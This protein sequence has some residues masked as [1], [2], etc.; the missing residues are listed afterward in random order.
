MLNQPT[1]D[2]QETPLFYAM[3]FIKDKLEKKLMVKTLIGLGADPTLKNHKGLYSYQAYADEYGMDDAALF[4]ERSIYFDQHKNKLKQIGSVFELDQDISK[5]NAQ[6]L[7]GLILDNWKEFIHDKPLEERLKDDLELAIA[8]KGKIGETLSEV[9][10]VQP[11]DAN[12]EYN[13][14]KSELKKKQIEIVGRDI[15]NSFQRFH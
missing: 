12:K 8:K 5:A 10:H 14:M 1:E 13:A 15:I 7:K 6:E 2:E 4:I 11:L 3:K 9:Q